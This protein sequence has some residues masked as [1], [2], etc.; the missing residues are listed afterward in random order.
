[1][2]Y[3]AGFKNQVVS[4]LLTGEV[5]ITQAQEQYGVSAFSLREWRE[6]ALSQAGESSTAETNAQENLQS[7]LGSG[8]P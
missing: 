6:K 2:R 8:A 7:K 5:T 1:M 4:R 3:S